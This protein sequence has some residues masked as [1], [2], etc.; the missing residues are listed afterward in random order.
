[1]SASGQAHALKE[2]YKRDYE[3][4]QKSEQMKKEIKTLR[5]NLFMMRKN[6]RIPSQ[7]RANSRTETKKPSS[8]QKLFTDNAEAHGEVGTNIFYNSPTETRRENG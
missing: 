1:M 4:W 6:V 7:K 5:G 8:E 3:M 2:F